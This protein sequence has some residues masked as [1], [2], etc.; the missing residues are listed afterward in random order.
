MRR[1]AWLMLL[2]PVG[3]LLPVQSAAG[4]PAAQER[5]S[6]D[7]GDGTVKIK[8]QRIDTEPSGST[9][10]YL[11]LQ[12]KTRTWRGR[13]RI[14]V[15]FYD[16]SGKLVDNGLSFS[17]Q[18]AVAPRQRIATYISDSP[19]STWDHLK[20]TF[21]SDPTRLRTV[22]RKVKVTAGQAAVVNGRFQLPVTVTNKNA[23]RIKHVAVYVT[24]FDAG[25]TIISSD[26]STHNYT[27]PR[28]LKPRRSGTYLADAFADYAGVHR[29]QIQ[30][31]A[32]RR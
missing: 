11:D 8:S 20:V 14:Q 16:A 30:V 9:G 13:I 1:I 26:L 22:S 25:G 12:N 10:V 6:C 23:F 31:E 17:D 18:I 15:C 19:T 3:F 29:V 4:Q 5:R 24:L 21:R 2:A 28:T 27:D 32:F 7:R